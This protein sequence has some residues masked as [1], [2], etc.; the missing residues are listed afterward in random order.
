M[1]SK[2]EPTELEDLIIEYALI[3][4]EDEAVCELIRQQDA[5]AE[6]DPD[7]ASNIQGLL[8]AKLYGFLKK[9][10]LSG[11]LVRQMKMAHLLVRKLHSG[12]LN[13]IDSSETRDFMRHEFKSFPW[14][15]GQK[16]HDA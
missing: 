6:N 8:D 9:K 14:Y 3:A 11:S 15:W 1:A 5:V 2:I 7:E 4:A 16:P 12:E 10:Q 13:Q